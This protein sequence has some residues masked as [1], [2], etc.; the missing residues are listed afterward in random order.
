MPRR[1]DSVRRPPPGT[2]AGAGSVLRAG[3]VV[4]PGKLVVMM[5]L[6][7]FIPV[8]LA[9]VLA[10]ICM[11][12]AHA[13]AQI[14]SDE[15]PE[16][17]RDLEV[18]EKLG[19]QIPLDLIFRN[20]DGAD[21]PLSRYFNQDKPVILALVY[22]T[23]PVTCSAVLDTMARRFADLDYTI[24]QDFNTVVISFDHTEETHHAAA[25][26]ARYLN[27]Y[28]RQLTSEQRRDGWAFH[29]S[30]VDTVRKLADSVGFSYRRLESGEYS[31]PTVLV[32]L[33]PDGRI[34][35]YVYGFSYSTRDLRRALLMAS[36][37]RI[38][39][40]IGDQITLFCYRY[41]P[42]AGA[43]TMEAMRVMQ[44]AAGLSVVVLA[45]FLLALFLQEKIKR[46]RAAR[47]ASDSPNDTPA[48]AGPDSTPRV[49]GAGEVR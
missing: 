45:L 20:A 2:A 26:Q 22:Y 13:P 36:E 47:P 16:Q 43:Y 24:G 10:A 18:D 25:R 23:C 27:A 33:T 37:G 44:I 17:A 29:T 12:A 11:V 46:G 40:S 4:E 48:N 3:A 1:P 39:R 14:I 38:A 49:A 19:D 41:D 9:A 6:H 15:L 42:T 31:H 32:M 34:N 30:D 28:G 8:R 35:S 21:V 5:R 7:T